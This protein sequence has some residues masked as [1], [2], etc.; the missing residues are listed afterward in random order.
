MVKQP[1]RLVDV[2]AFKVEPG[3]P[4]R[5]RKRPTSWLPEE[6]QGLPKSEVKAATL[7][8]LEDV[9]D[10]MSELQDKLY[11]ADSHALLLIFQAMDAA[12]KDG[13]IRHVMS[14]VNPQG[15]QA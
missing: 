7:S 11:A 2:D 6:V 15:C 4:A 5:L 12:G 10:E 3:S 1:H 13:T 9:R 14:G 8:L